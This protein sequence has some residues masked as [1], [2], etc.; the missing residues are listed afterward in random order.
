MCV[1]V[2]GGVCV[3]ELVPRRD[4]CILSLNMSYHIKPIESPC[5]VP[6]KP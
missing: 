6:P 1:L 3:C 2:P 5:L 4:I